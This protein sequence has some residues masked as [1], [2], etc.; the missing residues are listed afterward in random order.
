MTTVSEGPN[1]DRVGQVVNRRPIFNRPPP[2]LHQIAFCLVLALCAGRAS[3]QDI[4]SLYRAGVDRQRTGD[5]A[6]AVEL[7]RQCLVLAPD[8]VPARSNLGAALAGLGRFDEAIPEYEAALKAA[9][10]QVRPLLQQ[11][12]ALAYYKSGRAAEAAPIFAKLHAD[13]SADARIALLTADCYLQLGEATRARDVLLPFEPAAATEKPIAYLLGLALLSTGE[14]E[15]AEK[16]LD[17]LL[18]D[19]ASAEGNFAAGMV[20]FNA[21]NYPEAVKA[22]ARAAELNPALPRVYSYYGQ[23]L[24]TTGD[25]DGAEAA[26]Q[27]QLTVDAND[28][29]ANLRLSEILT[30][31]AKYTES[32]PLLRR[33][34]RV[35]PASVE[36][37]LALG[38]TLSAE[39]KNTEART[40]LEAVLRERPD[41]A[42]AHERLAAVYLALGLRIEA[43]RE[44]TAARRLAP[45]TEPADDGGIPAGRTAPVLTLTPAE[46]M[47]AVRIPPAPQR[48]AVLVFGSYTCPNFRGAAPA[49]NRLAAKYKDRADFILIYIREAHAAGQWQSTI[50]DR[51]HIEMAP[52][53]TME[54]KHEYATLCVRKL[55]MAFPAVVDGLDGAAEKAYRAWPSRAYI[56]DA[57][58]SIRYSSGLSQADFNER[59]F[60]S[61]LAAALPHSQKRTATH[62]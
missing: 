56:V 43:G 13:S 49:L 31:H 19:T 61:A 53:R 37:R 2:H 25:A 20:L 11:N 36:A 42:V 33:A 30:R 40:E 41:I 57:G 44:R 24:L 39:K 55:H 60:V 32:E 51:E 16:V 4:G 1:D 46:G 3:A 58:G 35:C 27:K 15:H 10:E 54:Q 59:D 23:A 5:L 6:G 12:L 62:P 29:E 50:N 18:R 21:Q 28:F 45:K 14:R 7:Y 38:E 17:P 9:P 8:N 52:A 47:R 26:F 34:L 22:Y 48:P